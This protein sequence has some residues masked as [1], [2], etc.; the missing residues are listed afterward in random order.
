[1][2]TLKEEVKKIEEYMSQKSPFGNFKRSEEP[3][4]R[5]LQR[6]VENSGRQVA[7]YEYILNQKKAIHAFDQLKLQAFLNGEEID[8]K[9]LASIEEKIAVFEEELSQYGVDKLCEKNNLVKE[10]N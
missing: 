9:S 4:F 2:P 3:Y 1:M 5:I 10:L 8:K 6:D 7:Y